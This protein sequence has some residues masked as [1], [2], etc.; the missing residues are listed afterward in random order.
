MNIWTYLIETPI[1]FIIHIY[2]NRFISQ[3]SPT[4]N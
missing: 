3:D 4:N 1:F 2:V